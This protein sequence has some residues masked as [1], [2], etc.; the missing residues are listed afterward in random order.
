[1]ARSP[2]STQVAGNSTASILCMLALLGGRLRSNEDIHYRD[3]RI[4]SGIARS[5]Q[6]LTLSVPDLHYRIRHAFNRAASSYDDVSR[7]FDEIGARLLTHLDPIN[8]D[9]NRVLD[10]GCGTGTSAGALAR[11]YRHA[12]VYAVDC[13]WPML[14]V[15]RTKRP[16]LFYREH[17]VCAR[18]E[19]LPVGD[20]SMDIFH[21]NLLLPWCPV[22]ELLLAECVRVLAPGAL[23]LISSL[24]PDTLMELRRIWA[25]DVEPVAVPGLLDMHE[26]GDALVDA[27]L[28]DI[29]VETERLTIQYESTARLL[30][31]LKRSGVWAARTTRGASDFVRGGFVK[32]RRRYRALLAGSRISV[33]VE[34]IYAH[35][36]APR[37]A[38]QH[39][40]SVASPHMAK[41]YN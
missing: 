2:H 22:L 35:G 30:D 21:A 38:S 33:T 10:V 41:R 18:A 17:Y 1:M 13:A 39:G 4:R 25:T 23:F 31:D 19:S 34:I 14:H 20:H 11:R 6:Y 5:F 9:P 40:I 15:A 32:D 29:V 3:R 7:V 26:L 28:G 36:W 8:I 16:R 12:R 37:F 24:G 27:G